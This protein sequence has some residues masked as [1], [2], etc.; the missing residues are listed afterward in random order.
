MAKGG[1][2]HLSAKARR[3]RLDQRKSSIRKKQFSLEPL[4]P[5]V[6]LAADGPRL[7]SISPNEG[8]LLTQGS[9][10][11]IAP[12]DLTFTFDDAQ[13][14]DPDTVGAIQIFR[15]N[16]EVVPG[17]I[18]I[19]TSP[20]EVV[21][22]FAETLTDGNYSVRVGSD[23][24]NDCGAGFS[25]SVSGNSNI[26]FSLDLG[27]QVV[28]VVPQPIV[29]SGSGLTQARNQIEVYFNDDD[30]AD[31][32]SAAEN[33]GFYQLVF[34]NDTATNTDD[35]V[36]LPANVA[37]DA[38]T[39][40]ATLTFA[41]NLDQ[42]G[43]GNG[44]FRLR[45]GDSSPM[46]LA[47][48]ERT[49]SVD[50]GDT[51]DDAHNLGPI[52][53]RSQLI[54]GSID[55]MPINITLPGSND[56]PGNRD[57][58]TLN[59]VGDVQRTAD[60][61]DG[62]TTIAYN[63]Q[64][65]IGFD[66]FGNPLF[67]L[68]T[69]AQKDRAREAF[70][71]WSNY[72]GVEFVETSSSGLLISTGDMRAI[73][74]AE[75]TGPNDGV[76]YAVEEDPTFE[77][78]RLILDNAEA[79][80]S[81]R[82]DSP[83]FNQ[84]GYFRSVMAGI[85][86]LLGLGSSDHLHQAVVQSTA[87]RLPFDISQPSE[88][89][90]PTPI[91]ITHGQFVHRPD[92]VDV[93]LYRFEVTTPGLFTAE[94]FAERQEDASLLDSTL[95]LYA[96]N[97]D[98]ERV[99]IASN[100]DYFSEDSRL[101]L[102]LENGVYFLGVSSTGNS[103]YNPNVEG[104][105]F[106]GTTQGAYDLRM[107]VVPNVENTLIDST[108]TSFDGDADGVPGGTYNF[109]FRSGSAENTIF[110]DKSAAGGGNGGLGSPFNQIDT[111]LAS[112]QPGDIVRILGNGGADNNLS[113]VADNIPYQIG[114]DTINQVTP[115]ADGASVIVP[116]GVTVMIDEGAVLKF[117]QSAILV[118]SSSASVDRSGAA[119][120]V[121][122]TPENSVFF[123]SINDDEI[124]RD[125]NNLT[126][127]GRSG[128]WGGIKFRNDVDK[129]E[130]R[131]TDESAGNF[132]NYVNHADMRFGGGL[133]TLDA[134]QAPVTPID[135]DT[136][137]PTISFN[138]ITQSSDAAMAA[139]PDAF[140]ETNFNTFEFQ[141]TPFTSDYTRIGP[142]IHGNRLTDNSI[143]GLFVRINTGAGSVREELTVS[144][145]WDD[146]DIVHVLAENLTVSGTVA[147]PFGNP[148]N[149]TPNIPVEQRFQMQ[150]NLDGSLTI[151][152]GI[153]VKSDGARIE[154]G[155][156]AQILAEGT[157]EQNII[158]T[159]IDDERFGAGGTFNTPNSTT[160]GRA[161]G[162]DWAGIYFDL[163]SSGSLDH[164]VVAFAGGVT[165]IEGTTTAFNP[166]EIHQAD[167][168]IT[169]SLF[170]DN[171]SGVS[172]DGSS[173]RG[174]RGANYPGAIF[175][176]GAQPVIVNNII[177]GTMA[178]PA[179]SLE[180][181][182]GRGP[183][184]SVDP[185]SLDHTELRDYGRST[186]RLDR[187]SAYDSNQGALIRGNRLGNNDLNGL[188]VRGATVSTQS[189]WDDTDIVHVVFD[190]IFVPNFEH[191]VGLR[192]ESSADESLVVKF[193][194][195]DAGF[196]A[197]GDRG[198]IADRIGGTVQVIG[199]PGNPVVLTSLTDSTVGAG[200]DPAGN[201][202]TG[203][204]G[205][206]VVPRT[207]PEGTFTIDYVF[208]PTLA[209]RP[210]IIDALERAA[211]FW[212]SRLEDPVTVVFD[213]DIN[214]L[215]GNTAGQASGEVIGIPYSTV[216]EQLIADARPHERYV[217]GLP[218]AGNLTATFPATA[219]P[220][221]TFQLNENIVLTY[222][223]AKAL[224]IDPATLPV[225]PSQFD[226]NIS[227]DGT[228]DIDTETDA[229]LAFEVMIHEIGHAL[230]FTSSVE[231]VGNA[232]GDVFLTPL[233]LFRFEPGDGGEDFTNS[234]R[235]LDPTL[236][237]VFYDGGVFNPAG[238]PITDIA[239]GD[240]PLSRGVDSVDG[241]QA[242][243]WRDEEALGGIYIGLMDPITGGAFTS[244]DARAFDVI[245]YDIVQ[246]EGIPGEWRGLVI[247]ELA[248]NR[249][250]EVLTET[251]SP[252]SSTSV[253]SSPGT[254][255]FIGNLA[256]AINAG[257]DVRRLGFEVHG[258]L[259]TQS[260][261]D[262]FS[263]DANAGTDVWIDIDQTTIGLDT[264]V[265]LVASDGS[266]LASSDDS[267]IESTGGSGASSLAGI[268]SSLTATSF[269]PVDLYSYNTKDAG[270]KISIPGADGTTGT[271][272]VRVRSL[273]GDGI[274]ELNLRLQAQDEIA[275]STV[276]YADIR[277]A[278]NGIEIIGQPSGSPFTGGISEVEGNDSFAT[279]Q[280]VG[281]VL[282]TESGGLQISGDISQFDD[283]D[284][285]EFVVDYENIIE[286]TFGEP[287]PIFFD[288]DYADGFGGPDTALWL[289]DDVGR[290]IAFSEDSSSDV[291]TGEDVFAP[292]NGS[293]GVFDPFLG[294]VHLRPGVYHLAV[295]SG[296]QAPEVLDIYDQD[297]AGSATPLLRTQPIES[298]RRVADDQIN[299]FLDTEGL[300]VTE[301]TFSE[302]IV[303][304]L[305]TD[306]TSV[307]IPNGS[308]LTPGETLTVTLPGSDT[309]ATFEFTSGLFQ[310]ATGSGENTLDGETITISSSFG[311]QVF[312]FVENASGQPGEIEVPF[313]RFMSDAE[314]AEQLRDAINASGFAVASI[315]GSD[316]NRV[317]LFNNFGNILG[318]TT[319]V[320]SNLEVGNPVQ[321]GNVPV[322]YGRSEV[323]EDIAD[324]LSTAIFD[325]LGILATVFEDL[326]IFDFAF[327]FN[328][329]LIDPPQ[330][331][332]DADST[333]I[334][335]E[336]SAVPWTLADVSLFVSRDFGA[337]NN[338]SSIATIDP[339]SGTLENVVGNVANPL[340][341][342]VFRDQFRGDGSDIFNDS[343]FSITLGPQDPGTRLTDA[344]V[345]GIL[346]IRP[347]T[348]AA[349]QIGAT[350]LQTFEFV[351]PDQD[352]QSGFM[353]QGVG[354]F[355][356]ALA[357]QSI[358]RADRFMWGVGSRGDGG[359][360]SNDFGTNIVYQ[361]D[362]NNGDIVG[363]GDNDRESPARF[364]GAGTQIREVGFFDTD[365]TIFDNTELTLIQPTLADG[366]I[367]ILDGQTFV[368]DGFVFEFNSGPEAQIDLDPVAGRLPSD[369]DSF[370]I[371]GQQFSFNTGPVLD[372]QLGGSAF[373]D[374]DTIAIRDEF[375]ISQ[376]FEF[377]TDGS[378]S[379]NNIPVTFAPGNSAAAMATTIA[380]AIS[381]APFFVDA[382][383][384]AGNRISLTGDTDLLVNAAAINAEGDYGSAAGVQID[385][386]EFFTVE[387]ITEAIADAVAS[388]GIEASASGTRLNFPGSNV[389]N[390]NA[391]DFLFDEPS[392]GMIAPTS[393]FAVPFGAGDTVEDLAIR[394]SAAINTSGIATSSPFNG[395]VFL[396]PTATFQS[397]EGGL[398]IGGAAPGGIVTGV[399]ISPTTGNLI[400][401]TDLGGLYEFNP[402]T[403]ETTYIRSATDLRGIRFEGLTNGPQS[404]EGGRYADMFFAIDDQGVLY[405]FDETGDLQPIFAGGAEQLA[406]GAVAPT[407]IEFSTLDRNLWHVTNQVGTR[408][409]DPG[410]GLDIPFTQSHL[411]VFGGDSFHFGT[412]S[413]RAIER[414]YD[415]AGGAHGSLISNPFSLLDY[416]AS[417]KPILSFN[418]FLETEGTVFSEAPFNPM[419]DSFRVFASTSDNPNSGE[420]HLLAT[421]NEYRDPTG[422]FDDE[423]ED[424]NRETNNGD[425]AD[426]INI[427][428]QD[429][430]DNTGNWRQARIDLS[431]FAGQDDIRLRFEFATAGGTAFGS[432][433]GDFANSLLNEGLEG[434]E[435]Q[436]IA[437]DRLRDGNTITVSDG[438]FFDRVGELDFGLTLVLPSGGRIRDGETVSISGPNGETSTFEFDRDGVIGTGNVGV[439][440][441][442]FMTA[443]AV[444]NALRVAIDSSDAA[445]LSS[446]GTR[447]ETFAARDRLNIPNA[448][449][450]TQGLSPD[451]SQLSVFVDGDIGV[452][453]GNFRIPVN[454]AMNST[455]VATAMEDFF[456]GS[457]G[458]IRRGDTFL[459]ANG[460]VSD[461]GPF[462]LATSLYGSSGFFPAFPDTGAFFPGDPGALGHIDNAHEGVYIDDIVV[463][464]EEHGVFVTNNG[465]WLNNP[466][467][468]AFE[469]SISRDSDGNITDD[470][471]LDGR[472]QLEIRTGPNYG[473][474]TGLSD[475][476]L[477]LGRDF[478]TNEP[479][480]GGTVLETKDGASISNGQRFTLNSESGSETFE[481][482]DSTLF[483]DND[484]IGTAF[485]SELEG[486][487]ASTFVGIGRLGDNLNGF[488][489]NNIRPQGMDVD[490]IA[491]DLVAGDRLQVDVDAF[492][493]DALAARGTGL[494]TEI[495]VWDESGNA[496]LATDN[497]S[498][499]P[500]DRIGD[501]LFLDPF[502][503][504]TAP[505]TGTYYVA[506]TFQ[507]V[508]YDPLV[509][510]TAEL[511]I[512]NRSTE[513]AGGTY[514]LTAKLNGGGAS[515]VLSDGTPGVPIHFATFDSA[516]DI[517]DRIAVA[518]ISSNL[519]ASFVPRANSNLIDVSGNINVG[520]EFF[521]LAPE[522]NDT[523]A[524][525][526]DTGL[527]VGRSAT[528]KASGEIGDN[529]DFVGGLAAID[530][531]MFA[532]TLGAGEELRI[533]VDA[534]TIGSMLDARVRVYDGEST[535]FLDEVIDPDFDPDQDFQLDPYRPSNSGALGENDL[536]TFSGVD[537]RLTFTAPF[538][539]TFFV[540]LSGFSNDTYDPTV[541]GS[542]RTFLA[543]DQGK[544]EL[545]LTTNGGGITSTGNASLP[546][547]S[548]LTSAQGQLLIAANQ[549]QYS[550]NYGILVRGADE[551]Q[552][553]RN[554]G[555]T[556]TTPLVP[557][558]TIVNNLVARNRTGGIRFAGNETRDD[559][560][561]EPVP[562]GRII[563]NTVVGVS[564]PQGFQGVGIEV[565]NNASPTLLNNIVAESDIGISIDATSGST[566]NVATL[567]KNN[568]VNFTG[569]TVGN[570]AIL[571]N[572]AAPLFVNS[573][574]DNFQLAAGSMAIDS[575]V[576]TLDDRGEM[577]AAR[578][579][580]GIPVSPILVPD[581]DVTGQ[582]RIDDPLIDTPDGQGSN[583]FKDRGAFDR[584][585]LSGPVAQF[586]NP[587]DNGDFDS[588]PTEG[589]VVSGELL[590]S[591]EIRLFDT[592]A[593][594]FDTGSGI[595]NSTVTP[596]SVTIFRDGVALALGEDYRFG[597]DAAS[598]IVRLTPVSGLWPSDSTYR[599]VLDNTSITDLAGNVLRPNQA[600]GSTELTVVLGL[601]RDYGDAPAVYPVLSGDNGASHG[602]RDGF[603]LGAGVSSEGNGSPSEG[604]NADDD[605]GLLSPLQ[606]VRGGVTQFSVQASAEGLLSVWVDWNN[607]G[608]W[609]DAGEQVFTGTLLAEGVNSLP[610]VSVPE[611][612]NSNEIFARF[613]FSS[614]MVSEPTGAAADGEVEDYRFFVVSNPWTNPD[615]SNDVN[616]NGS[617]SPLDALLVINE[618]NEPIVSDPSTGAL[619]VPIP[620]PAAFAP[621]FF[622]VNGDGFVSPI[623][624]L[625]VI[626]ELNE[627]TAAL[628]SS[629][630]VLGGNSLDEPTVLDGTLTNL[631]FGEFE[632]ETNQSDSLFNES[633]LDEIMGD[634]IN[635]YF[636]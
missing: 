531:D 587:V 348:A 566:E 94:T 516:E 132:V 172:A 152:P 18:G 253:N 154:A 384:V 388:A 349:N 536:A 281:N 149:T 332:V 510:G 568:R 418:Y 17:F 165:R 258:F 494:D 575:S 191:F 31:N 131:F 207:Q 119:L 616:A 567:Y 484:T 580:L 542:G 383:V 612:V 239:L 382:T 515:G 209:D 499:S 102:D 234:P 67:N 496:I 443:S 61:I 544:Y 171:A 490:I 270:M 161:N 178:T 44:T 180:N 71:L 522:S 278:N 298:I 523:F 506:V 51:F 480:D 520:A 475:V 226:A 470:R 13:N 203:T 63:F 391:T 14:I 551:V 38:T 328:T 141:S 211:Q 36:Y 112:A 46:P 583:V 268:A 594:G 397:A 24:A 410:H 421:N 473:T 482:V 6:L 335:S 263:F 118:G 413:A 350:G 608:D 347:D 314:V 185:N 572:P 507:G 420:W 264:V 535:Q 474:P 56:D 379:N 447:L 192:L 399:A 81:E 257:D 259:N 628:S 60:T 502:L 220:T 386:E 458:V 195:D 571:L 631:A 436:V 451:A 586:T 590:T 175:S 306:V 355:F 559:G 456:G 553:I 139:N 245:G 471:I 469:E 7:V 416:N 262:V 197:A 486:G 619:P 390:F 368:I 353:M 198:D 248:N 351:P 124:G 424:P 231:T 166:V 603:F 557:G 455:Q 344:N 163:T 214:Q 576:D 4:E 279:A 400:G 329:F 395:Q 434:E 552:A 529:D 269:Q 230:G 201:A 8:G 144:G 394:V 125:T 419:R 360:P 592:S 222:G 240:V 442:D 512:E 489:D 121:L 585:D 428:V 77:S 116:Q 448:V 354:V 437:A 622:D 453:P 99:L 283:L 212:E 69:E 90:F 582:L 538:A 405:A 205:G 294:P 97:E 126:D 301:A 5:K 509:A 320:G 322:F 546:G 202:Q 528:F 103:Q 412:T 589:I 537:P 147:A 92:S 135:M 478:D 579:Q 444:T 66:P 189:V 284:W 167:V 415:Y 75:N 39:D 375:N 41:S 402:G 477:L 58:Q 98:G 255:E 404:V 601:G 503:L 422:D 491:F 497:S 610:L 117:N 54:T 476:Q 614:Q 267:L 169:N 562:F 21:V 128:D 158:F 289:F 532:V 83:N 2:K 401:L 527:V 296:A 115:L 327:D 450:I 309:E 599:I 541:A 43:S 217:S 371:D 216:R 184:I 560:I 593:T 22:R 543:R 95:N 145:R 620:N 138:S 78:G 492:N 431:A 236:E 381:A 363:A 104:S 256:P 598:N 435:L 441:N 362:L 53:T 367:Q 68:I 385:V 186:G 321:P 514:K 276:R 498:P 334:V 225:A 100:D 311:D 479:L 366:T 517:A 317:L 524:T 464:F 29:R 266:V 282:D 250:V 408:A 34:T 292:S 540:A 288:I 370:T 318:V 624:A 37:Y 627:A 1:N 525:A 91:D 467:N 578:A 345:G 426:E 134:I 275:G 623:D 150:A 597:Y 596:E 539:G 372:I 105:G 406:T 505:A 193:F 57:L 561:V 429:L 312:R 472:Y 352:Q 229:D 504:Y 206:L 50:P 295:T 364:P 260:D 247:D 224:G 609:D 495:R 177:Q 210:D 343:L 87:P 501:Q 359:H 326:V 446:S 377:D 261:V 483:E 563:N 273:N 244:R 449:S 630:V 243:H 337:G 143:N 42:L 396:N 632:E 52:A 618:L 30:L 602:L 10:L 607:D 106:G 417:D 183:A 272:F 376:T 521:S 333:L 465:S 338:R 411:Q 252:N 241:E 549:I 556:S 302:P 232:G 277:Y 341:D 588:D 316:P 564:L 626:N 565:A 342:I 290:L 9:T 170:E 308:Q 89:I 430:F 591:F 11:N 457:D 346:E 168:R 28:S 286:P 291:A 223:N 271:Y 107:R 62:I 605:D 513:F 555:A 409:L 378:V 64:S 454:I 287:A 204:D 403:L 130:G 111:A 488:G 26:S 427:A 162:G 452:T 110:V 219:D 554:L 526:V 79:W 615:N 573:A 82:G 218:E 487:S 493:P 157:V 387:Q 35:V 32:T 33:P 93:D 303:P 485:L 558:V 200:F 463:G 59:G 625:L 173:N 251:E 109:W 460:S 299:T 65:Q 228:I 617:V 48:F 73:N 293:A 462:Q 425:E 433:S 548:D 398:T 213:A 84:Q 199:Q 481:Y 315:A 20:N 547:S 581:T 336:P 459:V 148:V 407:G 233:D 45:I 238:I 164:T 356:E 76:I 208:G 392:N 633:I 85:G 530:V 358:G 196:T 340:G 285:Y 508:N 606:V 113:T 122:G 188:V 114:F 389:G 611:T 16:V 108:G 519:G 237:H 432:G 577:A 518:G 280:V 182:G 584:A 323:A 274:Y 297:S 25:G 153:I 466:V 440:I 190:T 88:G 445:G 86:N 325:E 176:I 374:G 361:F 629:V 246:G 242:S 500:D 534:Q 265:E 74:P 550:Q 140:E 120:Q 160:T 533:D 357:M 613:R 12:N 194:G 249:N 47:P 305:L 159:S 365:T 101:Q 215:G 635:S 574:A 129:E 55:A 313:S 414:T 15:D 174:G 636:G 70:D 468:T 300:S 156:G 330:L 339:Y 127:N 331:G 304:N 133:V 621:P 439:E 72:L 142:D 179:E 604:A 570:F 393:D 545:T 511:P 227:I 19:G 600:N 96:E 40:S 80:Y 369:T 155:I 310:V 380:N 27:A 634:G 423:F 307:Q 461:P 136:V 569:T 235:V 187:F 373:S 254:A 324:R 181:G 146:T 151:D 3:K 123:T 221:D 319:L 23:L 49:P 438:F 137:R 595:D